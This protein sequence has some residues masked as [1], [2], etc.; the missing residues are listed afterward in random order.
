MSKPVDVGS[1]KIGQYVVIEGQPCRVVE[2]ERSKPGKHG[3][4]KARIVAIGVFTNQKKSIVS[5]VDAKIEVPMIEK[6]SGQVIAVFGDSV[7]LMDM[8]TYQTFET[9]SP[10]EE[11][12]RSRL[13][14][15]VEV[16]YWSILGRNKV[17]RIK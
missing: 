7:Q 13:A 11:E 10:T 12:I 2:Y 17:T 15:G 9:P 6:R 14:P 1:V 3:A 4:A 5:P 8:E 16:E